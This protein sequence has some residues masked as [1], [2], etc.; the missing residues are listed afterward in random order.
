M[1]ILAMRQKETIRLY[2]QASGA[3]I[4]TLELLPRNGR[5]HYPSI[6][7]AAPP[8]VRVERIRITP[9]PEEK[10]HAEH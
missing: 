7:I 9:L 1:L 4:A 3:E 2:D 6:G 10:N 8:A 5:Y